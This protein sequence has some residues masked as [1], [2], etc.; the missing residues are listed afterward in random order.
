MKVQFHFK[1][2]K[3]L[4]KIYCVQ[5]KLKYDPLFFYS[6]KKLPIL[7]FILSDVDGKSIECVAFGLE[8]EK[9]KKQ[10]EIDKIYQINFVNTSKNNKYIK[11]SHAFK[12]HLSIDS[13]I[14]K[15]KVQK[16][17]KRNKI[18][19]K[20]IQRKTKQKIKTLKTCTS[21]KKKESHQLSMVNFLISKRRKM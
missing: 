3:Q 15:T 20:S 11:T 12:L 18:C 8:A 5:G 17:I 16:Y 2:L 4:N 19:V 9:F 14:L 6:N 7:S 1:D 10:I 21:C 13:E